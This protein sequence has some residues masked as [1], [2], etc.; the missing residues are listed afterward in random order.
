MIKKER[1]CAKFVANTYVRHYV[2]RIEEKVQSEDVK[3]ANAA[4]AEYF[5]A[6]TIL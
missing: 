6:N 3:F 2:H 5:Y 4:V 1:K